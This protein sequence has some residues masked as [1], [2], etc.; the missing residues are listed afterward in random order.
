MHSI[1]LSAGLALLCLSAQAADPNT[2]RVPN[3]H[4]AHYTSVFQQHSPW[5]DDAVQPWAESNELVRLRGGW[6]GYAR[7]A[8]EAAKREA[9]NQTGDR[10]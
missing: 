2:E 7:E 10:P 9:E 6:R 3:S 5:G 1:L 8:A 4:G